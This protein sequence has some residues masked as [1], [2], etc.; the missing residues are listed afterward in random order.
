[1]TA[2]RLN[3]CW[4]R[5]GLCAFLLAPFSLLFILAA[6]LR[7]AAYRAGW[8]S[9]ERLPV[10][11]VIVGNISVGGSGKTPLVLWLTDR[12]R[13]AGYRPGIISRGYGGGCRT[14]CEVK[15]D[16][17]AYE[18]GDEPLLLRRRSGSPV[19]IGRDRPAAGMALLRAHPE[20]DVIVADDGMQHYRLAR[21]L[22]IA[23]VGGRQAF[24][25]GFRLPAGPLR[26]G[27]RRLNE[28]D[29]VV[30][31]GDTAGLA[32]ESSR[33]VFGM[34]LV[35]QVFYNLRS[36]GA[37][38]TAEEFREE[39]LIAV[40]GIGRPERFFDHLR[41]LGLS[42]SEQAF[43]DHHVFR[44]TDLPSVGQVLMTEKDAVKCAGFDIR[45]CWYLP[46]EAEVEEGLESLILHKLERMHGQQAA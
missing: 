31:N 2:G 16:S 6:W 22:E 33:P 10:P 29:A 11:V 41:T 34:H 44:K 30:V 39:P 3:R 19:F 40:A 13:R 26:E 5:R 20:V 28:V 4:C 42:F 1:M 17:Q 24:G 45:N 18:V 37:S 23:V 15:T 14:V 46:V 38:R 43:P 21:D 25:N 9:V 36:D 7:R 35:G 8:L 12:L 32:A 27:L